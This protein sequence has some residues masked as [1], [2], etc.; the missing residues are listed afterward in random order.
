MI[1]FVGP[2]VSQAAA[3]A[4]AR[5][6]AEIRP[7]LDGVTDPVERHRLE[8]A[9]LR[10]QRLPE[11]HDRRR[12]RPRRARAPPRRRRP[13]R[14]RR[15]LRRQRRVAGRDGGRVDL[16][17]ALRGA[18]PP[19]LV[20]TATSRSS[21][22]ATSSGSC[23]RPRPSP[24]ASSAGA[25]R[26]P[27]RHRRQPGSESS[28]PQRPA[29]RASL[30]PPSQ[31]DIET[32]Q[33]ITREQ[34]RKYAFDWRDEPLLRVKPGETLR[35]RDLRRQHRLLQD[36]R[37]Q[38][39][40]PASGPAS[41]ASPPLAN[42]IGGP[43]FARRRRAR[44]HAGRHASRTSSS[45][46]TRGSPSARGAARSANRRA[47][48]SCPATTPPRSSATRPARAARPA[49]A[50]CTS[51]TGSAGRSRRS[52]AR[53]ASRPDREVTTSL[54]GQGEWGGNLDIRDVAPG[55]PHPTC[56][57]FHPGALLL[58]GRRPRQPGRHRVHRHRR[59]DEGD[60]ARCSSTCVKGKTHPVDADREAG[61]DRRRSTPTG[62]WRSPSRRRRST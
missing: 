46:T 51:A 7:Q 16:P 27:A 28:E 36:A 19:R 55:Q 20:R 18:D 58:P 60:R 53:S 5:A 8:R 25:P 3:D 47:G 14:H 24:P 30:D 39:R 1:T 22:A 21:P 13:R 41:T 23:A 40:S 54:D 59:R 44:R 4:R 17:A 34:A 50:R 9:H 12:R 15:R 62:R 57:I 49:T 61:L 43:V 42:P 26:I 32:V 31:G 56:P 35:D 48:P 37:G 10:R 38:G 29:D 6:V 2:F 45:T 11:G 52:S 33:R